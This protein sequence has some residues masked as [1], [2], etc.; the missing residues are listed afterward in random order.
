M[1]GLGNSG[2]H[3]WQTFFETTGSR[4]IR[5]NQSNWEEPICV[6]WIEKLDRTLKDFD[7]SKV[8]L[9]G[10]S[11][12]CVTIAHW[13][14]KYRQTVKAAFLVAPSDVEVNSDKFPGHGFSPI[15]NEPLNFK[16]IVVASENDPWISPD[17]ARFFAKNWGSEFVNIGNA[18]HINA[19]SGYGE[20]LQ[21]LEMLKTLE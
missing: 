9:V 2:P 6:D 8:I 21:G 12:G 1:P 16:S 10:H 19:D 7:L 3:H 11:L 17:R 13:A 15:P 18:G 14:L 4:F 5:V 20:W